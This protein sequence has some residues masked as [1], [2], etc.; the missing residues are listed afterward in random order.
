MRLTWRLQRIHTPWTGAYASKPVA[1]SNGRL[2]HGQAEVLIH[3]GT[4]EPDR[5]SGS[6]HGDRRGTGMAAPGRE[7]AEQDEEGRPAD[8]GGP[9]CGW[10]VPPSRQ[11][12]EEC[13]EFA[14]RPRCEHVFKALLKLLCA[15]PPL[16]GRAPQPLGHL[17]PIGI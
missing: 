11:V 3:D 14:A 15:E 1:E 10:E 5:S 7:P 6:R 2:R 8:R 9:S 17:V 12:D 13:V 16:S 4:W